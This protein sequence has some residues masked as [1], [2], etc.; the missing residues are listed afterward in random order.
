[1]FEFSKKG[2]WADA[3]LNYATTVGEGTVVKGDFTHRGN[4]MLAGHLI[5]DIHQEG[6]TDEIGN[7][8]TAVIGKSGHLEGDIYSAHVIIIGRIDGSV[9]AKGRVEV[10]PGAVV[11]G[12]ITY[13]QIN[14]HPDAKVNGHLKCLLADETELSASSSGFDNEVINNVLPLTKA[15]GY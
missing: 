8:S 12:D 14:V 10:C 1:V 3:Q 4:M 9:H 11:C 2:Q 5:G 6:I 15:D 13:T 7:G